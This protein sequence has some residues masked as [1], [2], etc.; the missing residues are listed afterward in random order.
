MEIFDDMTTEP[1]ESL[2]V[3]LAVPLPALHSNPILP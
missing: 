1:R 2:V 3:K